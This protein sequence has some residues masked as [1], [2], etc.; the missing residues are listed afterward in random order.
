MFVGH[1]TDSKDQHD[2]RRTSGCVNLIWPH[3]LL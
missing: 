3:L 2:A 1:Y